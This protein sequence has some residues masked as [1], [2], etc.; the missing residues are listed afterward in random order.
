MLIINEQGGS[1]AIFK[2]TTLLAVLTLALCGSG[3]AEP[4]NVTTTAKL[5]PEQN[6][7]YQQC[8]SGADSGKDKFS[9]SEKIGYNNFCLCLAKKI[10]WQTLLD[11]PDQQKFFDQQFEKYQKGCATSNLDLTVIQEG[12]YNLCVTK[13]EE[14]RNQN[15][16]GPLLAG[17]MIKACECVAN[18][19]GAASYIEEQPSGKIKFNH[20]LIKTR[21]IA[22]T[23]EQYIAQPIEAA[24]KEFYE[25]CMMHLVSKDPAK[26]TVAQNFCSCIAS[27][28]DLAQLVKEQNPDNQDKLA[29]LRSKYTQE[30]KQKFPLK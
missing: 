29:A 30:C 7:F 6:D 26:S 3:Y 18:N 27:K 5:T 1:M 13:I 4:P 16:V 28:R 17:T 10:D 22:C 15:N 12:V 14:Q 2:T 20:A 21:L 8:T 23:H 24:Q 25:I 9:L 19:P 11:Q